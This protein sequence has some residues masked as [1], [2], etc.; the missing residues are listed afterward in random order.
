MKKQ[1]KENRKKLRTQDIIVVAVCVVAIIVIVLIVDVSNKKIQQKK[2]QLDYVQEQIQQENIEKESA[3]NPY[4]GVLL[5]EI[6][7]NGWVEFYNN[8]DIEQSLKG[9]K[10]S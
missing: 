7:Q 3:K 6:N 5:N 8:S 4:A 9:L 2:E 1:D 10:I